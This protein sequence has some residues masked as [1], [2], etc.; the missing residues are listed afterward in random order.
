MTESPSRDAHAET[1]AHH[2]SVCKACAMSCGANKP[3]TCQ[4]A[5]RLGQLERTVRR[6]HLAVWIALI[7]LIVLLAFWAFWL[8]QRTQSR[9]DSMPPEPMGMR[10]P[11]GPNGMPNQMRGMNGMNGNPN[12]KGNF[13]VR[14]ERSEND[15]DGKRDDDKP[16]KRVKRDGDPAQNAGEQSQ[17]PMPPSVK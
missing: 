9:R 12:D 13:E 10:N 15:K 16:K 17:S 11:R 8:G 2:A 14:I 3:A 5:E 6:L 1:N 7:A 4:G